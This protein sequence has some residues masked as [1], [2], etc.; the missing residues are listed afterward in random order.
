L[1]AMED[2]L[3][4]WK[5]VWGDKIN[6]WTSSV[7]LRRNSSVVDKYW[8]P[9]GFTKTFRALRSRQDLRRFL[10]S[11]A[12]N[13]VTINEQGV[14]VDYMTAMHINQELRTKKKRSI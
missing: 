1:D 12:K 2:D 7:V 8:H 11:C 14:E 10:D 9:P 6:L 3:E 13:H 4:R 5:Y